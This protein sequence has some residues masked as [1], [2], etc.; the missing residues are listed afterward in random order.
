MFV[1]LGKKLIWSFWIKNCV[2]IFK[3]KKGKKKRLNGISWK[4][5]DFENSV[6]QKLRVKA[7]KK[8]NFSHAW[9]RNI[10]FEKKI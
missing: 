8:K 5:F 4:K 2:F 3:E 10:I 6:A 1:F 7:K 9:I